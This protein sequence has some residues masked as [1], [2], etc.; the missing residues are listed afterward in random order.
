MN[1]V[2]SFYPVSYEAQREL[3]PFPVSLFPVRESIT[4][5]WFLSR[6][7]TGPFLVPVY[8][9]SNDV[10]FLHTGRRTY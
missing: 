10:K 5:I 2:L 3:F 4:S 8:D 9:I 6:I 7:L 1:K